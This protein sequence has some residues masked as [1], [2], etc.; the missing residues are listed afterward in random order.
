MP[1]FVKKLLSCTVLHFI[2][3]LSYLQ[4]GLR[5][6]IPASVHPGL[7]KLI[8]QCWDENP[9]LRPTFAEIIVELEDILQHV[10]VA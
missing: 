9:D 1:F 3:L 6:D 7:S 10:Q 2:T 5:L 4:Q 8:Q